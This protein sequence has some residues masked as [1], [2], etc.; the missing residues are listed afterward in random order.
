MLLLWI[1]FIIII[2][3]DLSRLDGSLKDQM[4]MVDQLMI[5]AKVSVRARVCVCVC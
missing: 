5:I 1:S 3:F 2:P 4:S